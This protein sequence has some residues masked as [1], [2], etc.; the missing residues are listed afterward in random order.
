MESGEKIALLGPNGSGKSTFMLLLAGY[1]QATEGHV[2]YFLNN[3]ELKHTHVG[4][5]IG[6]CLPNMETFDDFTLE[7]LLILHTSMRSMRCT[8]NVGALSTLLQFSKAETKR[9]IRFFS[10]GMR[11]RLKLG[12]ALLTDSS[13][14]MLDEPLTNMDDQGKSL[15]YAWLDEYLGTRLLLV[16]SNRSDEYLNCTRLIHVQDWL[17]ETH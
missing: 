7:Q 10:N 5:H 2:S 13:A 6:M 15:Y 16:A 14:V 17:S 11:Q 8:S 4:A 3:Q 1:L 12:L 9:Q